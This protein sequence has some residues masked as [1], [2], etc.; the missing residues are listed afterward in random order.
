MLLAAGFVIPNRYCIQNIAGSKS[1]T[2]E[3]RVRCG[4]VPPVEGNCGCEE[5][6][7]SKTHLN[8]MLRVVN[9]AYKVQVA[10]DVHLAAGYPIT[11]LETFI[12]SATPV[13]GH[14]PCMRNSNCSWDQA[15]SSSVCQHDISNVSLMSIWEW[16]EEPGCY[17]LEVKALNDLSSKTSCGSSS[18]FFAYFVPYISAIQ[19]FGWS[20][21]NTDHSFSIQG[22]ELLKSSNTASSLS[23][24]PVHAKVH[25]SY[26]ESN[27]CLSESSSVVEGHGELMFEYFETEQPSFRPPLFEK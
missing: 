6:C 18:E 5:F 20:R 17:G 9:D 4:T 21:N 27:A 23:S 26:D 3:L 15:G 12:Y 2:A 1:T 7:S 19:L 25:N 11:D 22:K 10:A 8:E 14:A 16:Y 24:H 13:I